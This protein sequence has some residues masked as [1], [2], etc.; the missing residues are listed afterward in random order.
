MLA[1]ELIVERLDLPILLMLLVQIVTDVCV[2]VAISAVMKLKPLCFLL[3][4]LRKGRE[5]L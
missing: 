3:D 5:R 1:V 2:H 4:I